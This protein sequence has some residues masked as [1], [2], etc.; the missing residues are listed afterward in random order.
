M[1]NHALRS[2]KVSFGLALLGGTGLAATAGFIDAVV[3]ARAGYAVTH[4]TGAASNLAADLALNKP[5]LAGVVLSVIAAFMLG[6]G[7]AGLLIA[8]SGLRIGRRYGLAML[9]EAALL[10][11][12]AVMLEDHTLAGASLAA[13]AAGLQNGLASTYAGLIV[14][15]THLTGIAT[16]LG[17]LAGA[18]LRTRTVEGWRFLMLAALMAGFLLGAGAGTIAQSEFA[19]HALLIPAGVLAPIGLCY[20]L[21]RRVTHR[22]V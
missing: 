10:A 3:L 17:F 7:I 4:V 15:T 5:T 1:E 14:R 8:E 16:D 21:W 2:D 18:W 19:R 11:A 13:A 9:L 6:A 12:A 22:S 20:F